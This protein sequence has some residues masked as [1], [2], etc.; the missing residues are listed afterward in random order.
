MQKSDNHHKENHTPP[1]ANGHPVPADAEKTAPP[2][3]RPKHD[4]NHRLKDDFHKKIL[5]IESKLKDAEDRY[6][7]MLDTARRMKAEYENS[8]K[9]TDGQFLEK[10]ENE[11]VSI[12]K[13]FIFVYDNLERAAA[14]MTPGTDPLEWKKGLDLIVKQY[15]TLLHRFGVTEIDSA[16]AAFD[17]NEHEA[18]MAADNPAVK[19]ETV[20][21]VLEKGYKLNA[22]VI[23]HAKVRVDK[24]C[25]Q[26]AVK[27]EKKA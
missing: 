26:P 12:L 17:P 18:V 6:E 7:A 27:E 16:N 1:E 4:D 22:K 5:E 21:A 11:K 10:L 2:D 14:A 19:H 24:P 15:M 25:P 13:E 8:R 9:R 20:A 23:R 3:E